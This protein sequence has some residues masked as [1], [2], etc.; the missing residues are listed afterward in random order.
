MITLRKFASVAIAAAT[1]TTVTGCANTGGLGDILG[2]VLGGSGAQN[3]QVTGSV[4]S[5]DTRNQIVNLRQSNGSNIALSYDNQTQVV[6]QN[7]NYSVTDLE[8]GDQ[9][10]ATVQ[11][12]TN[13]YYVSRVDV[14]QSGTTGTTTA[15]SQSIQGTVRQIDVTNGWFTV[16][17]S[18][19]GTVTVTMP[20]NPSR[21]DQATFQNLRSGD[22]VRLYG[23]YINSSRIELQRFY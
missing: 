6:Y 21:A 14:N 10:T 17:T 11:T 20:Y 7:R 9:V 22:F 4:Q 12:V 1:I 13:G 3:G 23:T 18:N 15:N 2:G 19:S 16:Q 5:V 8:A